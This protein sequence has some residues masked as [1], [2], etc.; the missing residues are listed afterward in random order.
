[1][2]EA[3]IGLFAMMVLAFLRIPIALSMGLVG[4]VGY[5]YMRDWNWTVAFAI[6]VTSTISRAYLK[7]GLSDPYLAIASAYFSRGIGVGTDTPRR[8]CRALA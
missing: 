6:S 3:L 5:A 8:Y 2:S 4:V 1:M 7:S